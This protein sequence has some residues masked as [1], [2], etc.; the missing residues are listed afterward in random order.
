[1]DPITHFKLFVREAFLDKNTCEQIVAAMCAGESIPATIYGKGKSS[2]IDDRVRRSLSYKLSP[3]IVE[4]VN[5]KLI[6][7]AL[8][9]E[10][11]FSFKINECEEPQF[12]RYGEGDFFVAHQD[13]NTGLLSL[14][15]EK[16][17]V[18]VVILLSSSEAHLGGELV[19]HDYRHNARLPFSNYKSGT[20]VAFPSQTTHEVT[21]VIEG[22]RFSIAC[23]YR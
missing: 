16:R 18:S 10:R 21:P 2:S 1:M 23:W 6:E 22:E 17:R 13:G 15:Q 14:D 3:G 7:C 4:L 5:G 9:I 11:H 20:L 8:E 19:F 12:L